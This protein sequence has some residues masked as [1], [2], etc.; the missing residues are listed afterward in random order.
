MLLMTAMVAYAQ[1]KARWLVA[2]PSGLTIT[3]RKGSR[4]VP[5]RDVR[6]VDDLGWWGGGPGAKRYYLE[7]S[8]GTYFTFLG[9]PEQMA[10]LKELRDGWTKR[11]IEERAR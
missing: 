5:W 1:T 4:L 7:L 3:Q 11:S 8:D 9:D 6:V 10:R 2:R